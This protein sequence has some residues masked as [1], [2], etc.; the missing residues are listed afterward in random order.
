MAWIIIGG[1]TKNVGKTTLICNIIAAFPRVGWTAVKISSHSHIPQDIKKLA[2]GAGWTIGQQNPN[3]DTHDTARFLRSGAVRAL[4]VQ[5]DASSLKSACA[6]LAHELASAQNVIVESA[7]AAGFL[8]HDLL[9]LLLD[10]AQDDFK[11]SASQQLD[12]ADAL[13]LRNADF[14][15]KET[16]YG[17]SQARVFAALA[18]GLDPRLIS[19]LAPTVGSPPQAARSG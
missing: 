12:R 7:S 1:Q 16:M 2:E 3:T 4:L 14:A 8:H 5:A 10:P 19:L 17:S 9:L 11:D 18:D 15:G 13:V 6:S